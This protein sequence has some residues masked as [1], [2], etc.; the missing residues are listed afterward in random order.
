M[1]R[2]ILEIIYL[3]TIIY[4]SYLYYKLFLNVVKQRRETKISIG[5]NNKK[6]ER[7]VR[8]HSNFCETVPFIVLLS[9]ILYFNNLLIFASLSLIILSV[10]RTIHA[11]SISKIDERIEDRRKGMRLT[12]FSFKIILFAILYYICTLIYFYVQ[13]SFNTTFLPQFIKHIPYF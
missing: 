10:G 12:F 3:S 5:I 6:L 7:A 13:A 11:N 8:A 4:L 2:T 9:F 1:L